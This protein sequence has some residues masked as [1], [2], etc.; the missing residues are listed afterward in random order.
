MATDRDINDNVLFCVTTPE[1]WDQVIDQALKLLKTVDSDIKVAI[2]TMDEAVTRCIRCDRVLF[3]RIKQFILDGGDVYLCK[4]SLDHFNIPV[5]RP[6]DY[7]DIVPS[8]VD[9]VKQRQQEGWK[10]VKS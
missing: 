2:V 4:Q 6:P 1:A 8:G 3:D 7:M 5:K 10:I 9:L